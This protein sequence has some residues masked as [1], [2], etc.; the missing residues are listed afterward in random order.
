[1]S[2]EQVSS[3]CVH[4][5]DVHAS[6]YAHM[7]HDWELTLPSHLQL[8]LPYHIDGFDKLEWDVANHFAVDC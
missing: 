2:H 1:M 8:W 4:T 3:I 7:I 6:R 5:V